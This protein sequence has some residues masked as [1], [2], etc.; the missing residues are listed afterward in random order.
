M[1]KYIAGA[2]IFLLLLIMAVLVLTSL[3]NKSNSSTQ[4]NQPALIPT[5]SLSGRTNPSRPRSS[6]T[7]QDEIRKISK[8]YSADQVKN[9]IDFQKK[10]PLSSAEFDMT[11]SESLGQYFIQKKTPDADQKINEFLQ[12]NNMQDVKDSFPNNFVSTTKPAA[13]IQRKAEDDLIKA[14]LENLK[15]S[16]EVVPLPIEGPAG[17]SGDQQN[18]IDSSKTVLSFNF[19]APKPKKTTVSGAGAIANP[20]V[21]DA[22]FNEAGARVG[23]PPK[24]LKAIMSIECGRLISATPDQDI[25]AWSAPGAPGLPRGHGCY[26]N[27]GGYGAYGPMQFV[28]GTFS[29]YGSAVNRYGGYAHAPSIQNIRDSVFAAAELF[30]LN[31]GATGPTWTLEQM[32][33]AYVCYAAGCSQYDTGRLGSDTQRLFETFLQRYNSY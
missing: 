31:S 17:K 12:Q 3:L 33:R 16:D 23:T 25:L 1:N 11:Y 10:L 7:T 6:M 8:T 32:K 19:G 13:A 22:I 15:M 5:V 14:R 27:Q 30:L 28:P 24:M 29:R 2:L 9:A 26:Q 18:L 20:T 4:Q 21:L